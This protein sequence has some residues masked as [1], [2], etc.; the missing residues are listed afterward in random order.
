MNVVVIGLSH[1]TS[2][3]ELRERFAFA[4][5]KIPG[6]LQE[7]R[8]SGI[9]SEAAILST[10]NRVEIYAATKLAPDAAFAEL[11]KFFVSQSAVIERD[12]V[13]D[14]G[15]PLPLSNTVVKA[16]EGW[17]SPKPGGSSLAPLQSD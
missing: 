8:A 9:A 3:V 14:C 1:R 10:C 13:L 15:S 4:D 12:S 5:E 16:P 6:A 11:K 17:R 2:P 7:L